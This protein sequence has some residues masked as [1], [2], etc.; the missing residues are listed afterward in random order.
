MPH[1]ATFLLIIINVYDLIAG[2]QD[3]WAVYYFSA[4]SRV[5][6]SALFYSFGPAWHGLAGAEMGTLVIL[7]RAMML[8]RGDRRN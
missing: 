5:A 8:D 3:N 7:V 1:P 2:L 6:A 4:V